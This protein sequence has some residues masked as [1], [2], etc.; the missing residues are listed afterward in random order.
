MRL[1]S[2]IPNL[3]TAELNRCHLSPAEACELAVVGV[4]SARGEKEAR[5]LLNN[6]ADR[7][8]LPFEKGGTG[9]TS[10]KLYS[11]K[12]AVMLRSFS[13]LVTNRRPYEFA[14]PIV[15]K[16]A[17]VTE[18]VISECH[19]LD[20]LDTAD[21]FEWFVV[22]STHERGP[23]P[24][25]IRRSEFTPENVARHP[26]NGVFNAGELIWSIFHR[27]PDFWSRDRLARGLDAPAGRYDGS[28]EQGLPLDPAHPWNRNLPPLERAKR[29]LEIEEYIAKRE[30]AERDG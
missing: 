3:T 28:D 2:Y 27:Y 29:L 23:E 6:L 7:E 18:K 5:K 15:Q 17:A 11:L 8:L 1:A 12:A 16:I 13:E 30:E 20:D 10:P 22:Y 24:R 19:S 9:R 26:D 25:A 14:Y 4:G 21:G